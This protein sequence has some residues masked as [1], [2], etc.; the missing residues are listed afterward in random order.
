MTAKFVIAA[1]VILVCSKDSNAQSAAGKELP[2]FMGRT[3]TVTEPPTD[4]SGLFP[5][6]PASVC[7]EGPPRRQCYTAP[8]D[9]GGSPTV[10]V[11]KMDKGA[12]ALFF[13]AASGGVSGFGIRFALLRPGDGDKLEDLFSTDTSVSNQSEHA[14]WN[15]STISNA[16]IFVTATFEWGP[17]ESHY[18]EHRYMISV[19]VR[20]PSS[21]VG[22]LH[23]YLEDRYMTVRKYDY[24]KGNILHSEKQEI[25]ARLKRVKVERQRAP[26]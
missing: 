17:D 10:A 23:Y 11:V 7:A 12:S 19:Y 2:K 3:V 21:L 13:T 16:P 24:E 6:G 1:L 20:L 9:Y 25:L 18:D 4:E 22:D 26:R 14:F 8:K 15:D 5:T